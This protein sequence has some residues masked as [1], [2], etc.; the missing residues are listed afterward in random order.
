MF[1]VAERS[2]TKEKGTVPAS[3]IRIIRFQLHFARMP[4]STTVISRIM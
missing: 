3:A 2:A 1:L 4:R